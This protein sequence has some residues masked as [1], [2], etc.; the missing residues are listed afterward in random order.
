MR[1]CLLVL[2]AAAGAGFLAACRTVPTLPA[3]AA[4]ATP[5]PAAK[6]RPVFAGE[7]VQIGDD[8]YVVLRCAVL[9][10]EGEEAKVYRGDEVVARLRIS[11]PAYPPF[12]A[13]DV[14]EGRPRPGD[15]IRP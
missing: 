1:P 11:G 2:V 4:E 12:I 15:R 10:S 9:P 5:T 6:P 3:P 8:G 13:A 14:I 7:V